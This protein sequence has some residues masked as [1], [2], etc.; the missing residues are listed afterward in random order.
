MKRAMQRAWGYVLQI[1][2]APL[3]IACGKYLERSGNNDVL[4]C[5]TC[6]DSIPIYR[7]VFYGPTFALVAVTSYDNEAVM[8]LLHFF[9]YRRFVNSVYT[10]DRLIKTYLAGLDFK[11]LIPEN[12]VIIPV[13]LYKKRLRER[14][15][16]QAEEIAKI[17][18]K[19]LN[20]P[21]E[22]TLLLKIKDTPHQTTLKNKAERKESVKNS[23]AV[24]EKS[25]VVDKG[26]ILVDD[27]YTSGAT[28]NEAVKMLRRTGAKN[29][30]G[31]VIAKTA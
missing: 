19:Y 22:G 7:T 21:V 23:F 1:F 16:N 10:L 28:M 14:G 12:A 29:I 17:L 24:Y 2:F 26:V 25:N 30:V 13:P 20:L 18:G 15:F 8:K 11:K 6:F 4:I 27:V 9:K 5:N 3:C 31:F